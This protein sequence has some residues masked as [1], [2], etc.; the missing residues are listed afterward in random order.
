MQDRTIKGACRQCRAEERPVG[1]VNARTHSAL[2]I[3]EACRA[4]RCTFCE[5]C[6]H[7]VPPPASPEAAVTQ[8]SATAYQAVC[9]NPGV[10]RLVQGVRVST[11][12]V[13]VGV[14]HL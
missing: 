10:Q 2:D 3:C 12:E 13:A 5:C 11:V 14:D 9:F 8:C 1:G 7:M 6:L 4:Y